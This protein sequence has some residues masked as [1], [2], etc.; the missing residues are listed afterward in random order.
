ML[1]SPFEQHS[2]CPSCARA[3]YA[4]GPAMP[5][6]SHPFPSPWPERGDLR[7]NVDHQRWSWK[8]RE[9]ES[10]HLKMYRTYTS[11]EEKQ[12]A[13]NTTII[14]KN[15]E[16]QVQVFTLFK[17]WIIII[18]NIYIY[19]T[20]GVQGSYGKHWETNSWV[21]APGLA[22]PGL[23]QSVYQDD[24]HHGGCQHWAKIPIQPCF[25]C[26]NP[27]SI[28]LEA[29]WFMSSMPVKMKEKREGHSETKTAHTHTRT[30]SI[31]IRYDQDTRNIS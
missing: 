17:L 28:N 15:Q 29:S 6:T 23:G 20:R 25:T 14:E 5:G 21:G 13:L 4:G 12:K 26:S 11:G 1:H 10:F 31:D 8:H 27:I 16:N 30:E 19:L 18:Y 7:T 3:R 2:L 9:I 24:G 22:L